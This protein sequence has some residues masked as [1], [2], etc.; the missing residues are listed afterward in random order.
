MVISRQTSAFA[1]RRHRLIN[2]SKVVKSQLKLKESFNYIANLCSLTA[3][4]LPIPFK[5]LN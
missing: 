1:L 4:S 2:F 3:I 5:I